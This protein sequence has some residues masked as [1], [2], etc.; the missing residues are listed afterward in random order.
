[1]KKMDRLIDRR[2]GA[3]MRQEGGEESEREI[4]IDLYSGVKDEEW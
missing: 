2:L 3:G 1:M 4:E